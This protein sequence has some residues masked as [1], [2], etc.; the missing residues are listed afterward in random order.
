MCGLCGIFQGGEHW[1]DAS[2]G[3]DS[4]TGHARRRARLQRVALT[5]KVLKHY[6][7]KLADWNGSTY[8]LSNQTGQQQIVDS[9]AALWPAAEALR[10]RRLDPLDNALLA[11]LERQ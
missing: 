10:K 4:E 2:L 7:L 8:V 1:T 3:P 9:I 11:A 5:N 6:G